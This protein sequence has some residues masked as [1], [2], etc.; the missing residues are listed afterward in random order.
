MWKYTMPSDWNEYY[1]L[2][3]QLA[4]EPGEA[5]RRS[6]ISR[7][8]YAAYWKARE[9]LEYSGP[10]PRG[11]SSHQY[12]WDRFY[13][14]LCSAGNTIGDVGNFLRRK[15]TDA[16]YVANKYISKGDVDIV[17]SRAAAIISDISKLTP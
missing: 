17:L 3:K 15:R 8:Y 7:A 1:D 13:S 4:L 11:E 9:L 5:Q 12:V 10:I 14:D 6:A 2:A 16:D